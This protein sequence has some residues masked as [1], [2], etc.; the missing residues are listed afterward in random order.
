MEKIKKLGN[1]LI[2]G[3]KDLTKSYPITI[4]IVIIAT[5]FMTIFMEDLDDLL[6]KIFAFMLFDAFATFFCET[7]F[8]SKNNILKYILIGIF[9]II[10]LIMVNLY[11]IFKINELLQGRIFFTYCS[12]LLILSIYNSLKNSKLEFH[13]YLIRVFT[14]IFKT[15]ISYGILMIG[16][17]I[18]TAVFIYLILNGNGYD[19][20]LR[21]TVLIFG[22]YFIPFM[23][24][25]ITNV[26]ENTGKFTKGLVIYLLL[27]LVIISFIII[28]IYIVK[29]LVLWQIPSNQIF[30]ILF[31]LFIVGI[32][33]IIMSK[34][35]N[36]IKYVNKST[37]IMPYLFIPFIILQAYSLGIRC[38]E[39][40]LTITRYMGWMILAFEIV[41]IFLMLYKK[42][43][44]LSKILIVLCVIVTISVLLPY[45]NMYETPARNQA[46]VIQEY[47]AN[48]NISE[49]QKK[50]VYGAYTYLKYDDYREKYMPELTEEQIT[51]I[52][53]MSGYNSIS[54]YHLVSYTYDKESVDIRGYNKIYLMSSSSY[55]NNDLTKMQFRSS[56]NYNYKRQLN[57][58]Q[59]IDNYIQAE[60]NGDEIV[61]NEFVLEDGVKMI[62]KRLYINYEKEVD[63]IIYNSLSMD[64]YLLE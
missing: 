64:I 11:E 45:I 50:R 15:I 62:I 16:V 33:T 17:L 1:K 41:T 60:E 4:G 25:S 59:I 18:I 46:K 37:K 12:I 51:E 39:N 47:L 32:P 6:I 55:S 28:Y 63:N 20:L 49:S 23:I 56:D 40:G 31:A 27:P 22:V 36:N 44:Y 13:T 61:E 9:S 3:V 35:F 2:S 38:L 8:E 58:K 48:S 52:E 7:R 21:F 54:N 57:V 14:N 10:S 43:K 34:N 26:K 42:S 19:I 24:K 29:I 5:I 53:E 30:R